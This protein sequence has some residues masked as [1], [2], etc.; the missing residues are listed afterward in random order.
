MALVAPLGPNS[1]GTGTIVNGKVATKD[2]AGNTQVPSTLN[3]WALRETSGSGA[4]FLRFREGTLTGRL[5]VS[6]GVPS[7]GSSNVALAG[8]DALAL[9]NVNAAAAS[10]GLYVEVGGT[11]N[12]EGTSFWG[13]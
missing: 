9:F 7:S 6:I 12:L 5:I 2:Q 10:Q 13:F 11:G 1:D 4:A 3:G 8:G